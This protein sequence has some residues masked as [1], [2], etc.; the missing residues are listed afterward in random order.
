[1]S[2]G[3]PFMPPPLPGGFVTAGGEPPP[4]PLGGPPPGACPPGGPPPGAPPPPW[5]HASAL[6]AL[7]GMKAGFTVCMD[8][9]RM[10]APE[11][12]VP[13]SMGG[14]SVQIDSAATMCTI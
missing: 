11:M 7:A 8:A 2:R 4:P 6:N 13:R 3:H 5:M 12:F 10:A 1:M 9:L 14:G